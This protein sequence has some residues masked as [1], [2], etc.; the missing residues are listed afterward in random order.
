MTLEELEI[1]VNQI[2][3]QV[4]LNTL[5]IQS[6][7]NRL[8]EYT[9]LGSF[10]AVN[11]KVDKQD[12]VIKDIQDKVAVLNLDI[13][14]VNKLAG[15][16]DTNITQPVINEILRYD[17]NRW[18][19]VKVADIISGGGVSKLED[20]TDVKILNKA[21]KQSLVWDNASAKWINYTISGGGSTGGL[22]IP[23]MWTE[24]ATNDNSKTIHPSHIT[25]FI[26]ST[27]GTVANLTITNS[28]TTNGLVS[29]SNGSS[30]FNLL[31]SGVSIN[32]G[33]TSTGEITAYKIAQ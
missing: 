1:L 13:S 25:G 32:G 10:Y 27:G 33:L 7:A 20:L 26:S 24:L 28:L 21:D 23:A 11:S 9:P 4:D 6:L 2:K 31:T 29:M 17:G 14:K 15:M 8:S 19:N 22:D 30:A 12:V 16:L 5:A 18:T 3:E